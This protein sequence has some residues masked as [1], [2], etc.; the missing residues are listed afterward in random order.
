MGCQKELLVFEDE[1]VC[2]EV[3]LDRRVVTPGPDFT[4]L[5]VLL[6]GERVK[7]NL[8]FGGSNFADPV[9]LAVGLT[10]EI[11]VACSLRLVFL[12]AGVFFAPSNYDV[13]FLK[14]LQ[15]VYPLRKS[16]ELFNVGSIFSRQEI[17]WQGFHQLAI[18]FRLQRIV[19]LSR[20]IKFYLR[21]VQLSLWFRILSIL[22]FFG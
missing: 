21:V 3:V 8:V 22:E 10:L 16:L 2:Y 11:R 17:H 4:L 19:F 20:L 1:H 9:G 6:L 14:D 7:H 15:T 5:V 13:V 18:L 12:I